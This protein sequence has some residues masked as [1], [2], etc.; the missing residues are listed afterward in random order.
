MVEELALADDALATCVDAAAWAL[1]EHDL[2]AALDAAHRLE[3]RL[4]A[5]KLALV[6]EI[7]G[8]GT[9]RAQGASCTA[10]WLRE[11]LRLTVP[12]ARRLIDLAT[13]LDTSNPGIRKALADGHLSL[14]Q[15]RVIT[16]T[17][18]TVHETA[19]TEAADKAVSLLT[20]WAAQ[21]DPTHLRKLG[22]RILDH[23]APDLADA[24]TRAALEAEARRAT[25]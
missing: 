9:A 1:P 5:V 11:R 25:R 17:A 6:R 3:Q 22:T 8:R 20:D 19:G 7:D 2:I 24:A 21:F 4:A 18:T 15:A 16:D 23:V 12:A 10:V 13:A 14:D